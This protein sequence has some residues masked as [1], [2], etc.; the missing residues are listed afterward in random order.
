MFIRRRHLTIG[1]LVA[2]L[3]GFLN[4]AILHHSET[5]GQK[6][7]ASL[8]ALACSQASPSLFWLTVGPTSIWEHKHGRIRN[9]LRGAAW[10]GGNRAIVG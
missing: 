7:E 2:F 10:S 9:A 1:A 3:A 8:Y 5:M 6:P 4:D